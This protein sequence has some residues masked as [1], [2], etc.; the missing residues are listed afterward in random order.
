MRLI[1]M[2]QQAFGKA[3]L[4]ALLA[5]S[6]EVVAVYCAPDKEG[7]PVDPIKECALEKGLPVY[8]PASFKDEAVLD[9]LR[10]LKADLC[11]MAYVTIFVP[12][13]ARDIPTHGSICFHPSL[14][15]LHRG[16]S[17][18]NWPIIAG[19]TKTG[20]TIFYPNDGLDE[21]DILLQKEVE[22][23]PDDTLGTVYFNKIF[24]L[25]VDAMLEAVDLIAAGNA[26][27]IPQDH[28]KATYESWCKREHAE[29]EWSKPVDEV[30]N[31]IRGT[32]PQPGAWTTCDGKTLQIFDSAK[33]AD[34]D[35]APGEVTAVGDD[36]ITVAAPGGA[37]LV[38]RVRPEGEAK[39]IPAAEFAARAG[40]AKGARLG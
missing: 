7:R 10:A 24:Q 39:K 20:L 3:V 28:S 22:I 31:L 32:N 2:G 1:V 37:I 19:E 8:Q 40:L 27:R 34:G 12:E 38:K 25:G 23:G 14:L 36:G 13:A 11:V 16:P 29:I 5:R 6:D 30:Y 17:S 26:P 9:Q 35:G 18:I 33:L 15:P 4:E 21:G